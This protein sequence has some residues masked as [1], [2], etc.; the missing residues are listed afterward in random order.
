MRGL[1][2]PKEQEAVRDILETGRKKEDA[3]Q[4]KEMKED[5]KERLYK[6][7]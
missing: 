1:I 3:Q 4:K 6:I 7:N 2:V 5:G